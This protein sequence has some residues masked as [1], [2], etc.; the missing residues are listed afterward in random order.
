MISG[1]EKRDER[2]FPR[3]ADLCSRDEGHVD[4]EPQEE[5]LL[6]MRTFQGPP[7]FLLLDPSTFCET[8]KKKKKRTKKERAS[9]SP[10]TRFE[11][12]T[13]SVVVLLIRSPLGAAR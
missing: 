8:K 9:K 1:R 2:P 3:R 12:V 10:R 4:A 13:R 5:G 6:P 7:S 11:D